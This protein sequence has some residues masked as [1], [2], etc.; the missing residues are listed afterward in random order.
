M[1]FTDMYYSLVHG[2]VI[3]SGEKWAGSDMMS[4]SKKFIEVSAPQMYALRVY[5]VFFRIRH[6]NDLFACK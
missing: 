5:W 3:E 6:T 1:S 4:T 2:R